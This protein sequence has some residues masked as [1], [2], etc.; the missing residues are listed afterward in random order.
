MIVLRSYGPDFDTRH[1]DFR[2]AP[3]DEIVLIR[4]HI[5][6][7]GAAAYCWCE[8]SRYDRVSQL[9]AARTPTH[10]PSFA[11]QLAVPA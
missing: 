4:Q 10:I 7:G 8:K 2:P 3:N 5:A 6:D 11:A 1:H 9:V